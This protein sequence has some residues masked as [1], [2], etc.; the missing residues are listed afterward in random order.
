MKGTVKI[1]SAL[2]VV[3]MLIMVATPVFAQKPKDILTAV[4]TKIAADTTDPD[5]N[6]KIKETAARIIKIIRYAAVILGVVLIAVFGLKFMI[7]SA[8]EKAEYKKSFVPL[9]IGIVVVFGATYIAQ[10]IFSIAGT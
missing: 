1:I 8:E 3:L 6:G 7:G 4:D 10:L 5:S 2:L 9:I